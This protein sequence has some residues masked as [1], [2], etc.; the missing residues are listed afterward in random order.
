MTNPLRAACRAGQCPDTGPTRTPS[1]TAALRPFSPH[2]GRA[3]GFC[4]AEVAVAPGRRA[5]EAGSLSGL[6]GSGR[7]RSVGAGYRSPPERSRLHRSRRGFPPVS[8]NDLSP[9]RRSLGTAGFWKPSRRDSSA[10]RPGTGFEGGKIFTPWRSVPRVASGCFRLLPGTCPAEPI[11][12]AGSTGWICS[13]RRP[14]S[15]GRSRA[16]GSSILNG[17]TTLKSRGGGPRRGGSPT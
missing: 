1:P 17:A 15:C 16:P 11:P 13:R 14:S 2:G 8:G 12:I 6:Y 4:A 3:G 10:G 5:G 9:E 7:Q